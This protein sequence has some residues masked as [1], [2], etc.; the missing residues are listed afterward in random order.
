MTTSRGPEDLLAKTRKQKEITGG[1]L[2]QE[3]PRTKSTKKKV[4]DT[5]ESRRSKE[6]AARK[7]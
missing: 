3:G 4:K 7:K 6:R 1:S 5:L 2:A